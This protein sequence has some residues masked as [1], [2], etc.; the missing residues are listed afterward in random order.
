MP[1]SM[2]IALAVISRIRIGLEPGFQTN[3]KI[4]EFYK[5]LIR[6]FHADPNFDGD[7]DKGFIIQGP[8]GTG[9]TL[10]MQVMSIYRTIDDIK[11]IKGGITYRMN[12]EISSVNDITTRF[13]DNAFDGIQIFSNRFALC[14]DDIGNELD[15]VKHFGNTLDVIGYILSERYSKGLLTF[16]TTNYNNN[17][18]ESKY[19]D[20]IMSRMH[21]MFNFITLNG[22]DYRKIKKAT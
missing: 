13:I 3:P 2:D 11:F 1:Y 16:G 15:Q 8:T 10:A 22:A 19:G 6:W 20:R 12:F 21:A 7:I 5:N 17:L 4:D 18:L 9:K 14:L